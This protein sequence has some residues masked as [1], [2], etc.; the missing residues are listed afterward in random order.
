MKACE[1]EEEEDQ[2][3]GTPLNSQECP[4]LEDI[5][6]PGREACSDTRSKIYALVGMLACSTHKK[7]KAISVPLQGSVFPNQVG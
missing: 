4:R 6:I 7:C 5:L 3:K 2:D 1:A